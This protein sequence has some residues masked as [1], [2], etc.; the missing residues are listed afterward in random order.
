[1]PATADSPHEC[2]VRLW[3]TLADTDMLPSQWLEDT[4]CHIPPL[5]ARISKMQA[6]RQQPLVVGI[7][8]AQ[9]TGKSTLAKAVAIMLENQYHLKTTTLSLD[10]FY[11]SRQARQQLGNSIHPLLSTRGVPGTHDISQAL[12]TLQQLRGDNG[13][14]SLPGFDKSRDDCVAPQNRR[15]TCTPRD[16]IILEGWCVGVLPQDTESLK[17]PVN[18][19]EAEEDADGR[20]RHYV[21]DCLAREYQ[22]LFAS[23]DYL[24]MLK[25]PSF[26]CVLAWR[27]LQEAK[28]AAQQQTDNAARSRIMTPDA[29]KRFI[30]HYERLTRHAFATLPAHADAVLDLDTDH[31]IRDSYYQTH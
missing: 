12:T 21:N 3:Q 4:I 30:Q 19:L 1:M 2:I 11:L 24:V 9:G 14:V 18:V 8:G 17:T 26:D 27:S 20:W 22:N 7:N 6:A 10:D 28:L 31:R 16:V 5:T 13:D 23:I 25:A 29:I 15:H